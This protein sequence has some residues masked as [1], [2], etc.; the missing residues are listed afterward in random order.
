MPQE[1]DQRAWF[2]VRVN[3]NARLQRCGRGE[4]RA[5]CRRRA[6]EYSPDMDAIWIIVVCLL[7][8]IILSLANALYHLSSGRGD[9][10]KMLRAL[11]VRVALSLVLFALLMIAWRVGLITPRGLQH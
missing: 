6:D 2:K 4:G 5:L 8:A 11:T 3:G 10:G 1:A 7:V 9:S